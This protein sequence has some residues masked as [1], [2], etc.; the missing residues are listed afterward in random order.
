[1]L[2]SL[3]ARADIAYLKGKDK[4]AK[5]IYEKALKVLEEDQFLGGSN[6]LVGDMYRRL[7]ELNLGEILKERLFK[8]DE[9]WKQV[10]VS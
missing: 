2:P 4:V 5:E 9:N 10:M 8:N 1:M 7:A 6:S 3:T